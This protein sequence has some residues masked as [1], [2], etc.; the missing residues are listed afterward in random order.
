LYTAS[1]EDADPVVL[2]G[3]LLG[4]G[5]SAAAVKDPGPVVDRA[6]VL[7]KHEDPAVRGRA[8][9]VLG[10]LGASRTEAFTA[11]TAGLTDKEG[12]VRA[13]ACL[14][15]ASL[16]HPGSVHA[17]MPL[18][19]DTQS[20][21]YVQTGFKGLDGSNAKAKHSGPALDTVGAAALEA[22]AKL[23]GETV[24]LPAL[25]QKSKPEDVKLAADAA[26][27]WYTETKKSLPAEGSLPTT[28]KAGPS[29]KPATGTN[30]P[31]TVTPAAVKPAGAPAAPAAAPAAAS[32]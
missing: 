22:I 28:A 27:T 18:V 7:A 15:L 25:G 13:Q 8:L 1:L 21:T 5:R 30:K 16:G 9:A 26:K 2:A 3:A 29:V 17:I 31:T 20:A 11:A 10:A 24:K 4:I 23:G 12:F 6:L 14:A 32:K 19:D